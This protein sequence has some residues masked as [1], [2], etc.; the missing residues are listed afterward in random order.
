MVLPVTVLLSSIVFIFRTVALLSLMIYPL[1]PLRG[2]LGLSSFMSPNIG[3]DIFSF[4]SACAAVASLFTRFGVS[5]GKSFSLRYSVSAVF[6]TL[7]AGAVC[8]QTFGSCWLLSNDDCIFGC[9][10]HPGSKLCY[11][12]LER[13]FSTNKSRSFPCS[14]ILFS[15]PALKSGQ[16]MGTS[17]LDGLLP[18]TPD[19]A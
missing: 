3:V 12:V 4:R 1:L 15:D 18:S 8:R 13:C 9:G 11:K 16:Y 10:S 14:S 2:S 6:A 19:N 17:P 5:D 7:T